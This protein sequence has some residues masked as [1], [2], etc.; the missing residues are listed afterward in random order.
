M[1]VS[2]RELGKVGGRYCSDAAGVWRGGF[3]CCTSTAAG[4]WMSV[5][6]CPSSLLV[7]PLGWL[8]CLEITQTCIWPS[9]VSSALLSV[10]GIISSRKC[11]LAPSIP[12]SPQPRVVLP[13]SL[14]LHLLLCFSQ[15]PLLGKEGPESSVHYSC[16]SRP[17]K[18]KGP[19]KHL[20]SNDNKEILEV[21]DNHPICF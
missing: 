9:K 5:G 4:I 8:I 3:L 21:G 6:C 2:S 11:F 13:D 12:S 14:S 18:K 7:S 16:V 20:K 19:I 1:N 10:A 15:V 17:D